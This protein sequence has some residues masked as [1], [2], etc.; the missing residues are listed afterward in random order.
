MFLALSL[1]SADP[2]TN[3]Q[4]YF[5]FSFKMRPWSLFHAILQSVW[6]FPP[7]TGNQVAKAI[8]HHHNIVPKCMVHCIYGAQSSNVCEPCYYPFDWYDILI[9]NIFGHQYTPEK[10][11]D[12]LSSG[13]GRFVSNQSTRGGVCRDGFFLKGISESIIETVSSFPTCRYATEH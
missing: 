13:T 2:F 12:H 9:T 11:Y 6:S 10:Y 5:F 4:Y 7:L 3:L 1:L 8:D